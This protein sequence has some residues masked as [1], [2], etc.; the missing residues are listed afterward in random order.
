MLYNMHYPGWQEIIV[1]I[2]VLA[3]VACLVKTFINQC[4]P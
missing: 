1:G 3:A 4:R 2:V